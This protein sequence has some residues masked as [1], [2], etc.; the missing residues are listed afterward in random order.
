MKNLTSAVESVTE[1]LSLM[2]RI[3]DSFRFPPEILKNS[4]NVQ[5]TLKES[6]E[7]TVFD[8]SNV[9]RCHACYG[10]RH[11]ACEEAATTGSEL[12]NDFARFD[13]IKHK[14]SV[15]V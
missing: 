11:D 14:L 7:L 2:G 4:L 5:G 6:S 3:S 15:K 8:N 12:R 9:D 1:R 10:M 13:E